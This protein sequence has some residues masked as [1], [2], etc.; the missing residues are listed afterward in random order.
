[1]AMFLP[2]HDCAIAEI[3]QSSGTTGEEAGAD[4]QRCRTRQ[5]VIDENKSGSVSGESSASLPMNT[6]TSQLAEGFTDDGR[7]SKYDN[8]RFIFSGK[9]II[10]R[11]LHKLRE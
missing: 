2:L 10:E 4:E 8:L 3:P 5:S 1:M 7:L 6:T 9:K 11:H